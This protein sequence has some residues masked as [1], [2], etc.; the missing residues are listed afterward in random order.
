[1]AKKEEKE[2]KNKTK[3]TVAKKEIKKT[4]KVAKKSYGEEVKAELKKVKWPSKK[5]MVKYTITTVCFVVLFALFFFGIESLFAF[6]KGL[7][8]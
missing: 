1:M 6:I 7:I 3:K 8:G 5:E 4:N 2:L